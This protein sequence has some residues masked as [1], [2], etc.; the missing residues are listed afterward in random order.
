M[1]KPLRTFLV[2]SPDGGDIIIVQAYSHGQAKN[3]ARGEDMPWCDAD[4]VDLRA[5]LEHKAQQYLT[6]GEEALAW[7]W[8]SVKFRRRYRDLGYQ[9]H[10]ADSCDS[11]GGFEDDE[12]AESRLD[13]NRQCEECRAVESATPELA[14]S[15]P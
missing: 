5:K 14:E 7:G 8:D 11:C 9:M 2:T 3:I 6:E 1:R 15:A 12:I 13:E 10:D 4:F